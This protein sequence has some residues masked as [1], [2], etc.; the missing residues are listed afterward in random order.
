M[1]SKSFDSNIYEPIRELW[2]NIA[3]SSAHS[4]LI[5][6]PKQSKGK[7]GLWSNDKDKMLLECKY[8]KIEPIYEEDGNHLFF[9]FVSE[10]LDID[11]IFDGG[12]Y[13][14]ELEKFIITPGKYFVVRPVF[15]LKR[16]VAFILNN[17]KI[18]IINRNGKIICPE[19]FDHNVSCN[20]PFYSNEDIRI[21][22]Q[23]QEMILTYYD[24]TASGVENP[25]YFALRKNGDVFLYDING[26]L[27]FQEGYQ[28][29]D[30]ILSRIHKHNFHGHISEYKDVYLK[31]ATKNAYG[32]LTL[33]GDEIIPCEYEKLE[34]IHSMDIV[35]A[36]R[37]GVYRIFNMD[38]IIEV[39]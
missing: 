26:N 4:F 11:T 21:S 16:I 9:F 2:H 15:S 36:K 37:N 33:Y 29:I 5:V 32:L 6:R 17:N 8:E 20:I 3:Y 38:Y 30:L 24:K 7:L 23:K 1:M 25:I 12:Y 10:S 18:G 19:E 22:A 13:S 14:T 28:R 35:I 31:V 39:P 34:Y 27:L